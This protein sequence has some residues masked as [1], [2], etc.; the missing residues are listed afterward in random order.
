MNKDFGKT[1]V[2]LFLD[3]LASNEPVPGGGTAAAIVGAMAAALV[4]MVCNLTINKKKYVSFKRRATAIRGEAH[5]IRYRLMKLA[6]DDSKAFLAVIKAYK[7]KNIAGIRKA[8]KKA[9]EI[10]GMTIVACKRIE[11]MARE[12]VK[13]GNKNAVSDAQTAIQ[14][15]RAAAI[16]ARANVVLNKKALSRVN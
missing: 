10:P 5:A 6:N 8:L 13:K 14:L 4:E 2:K 11:I 15:A 16:S 9:I 7:K 12:L 1:S 3:N